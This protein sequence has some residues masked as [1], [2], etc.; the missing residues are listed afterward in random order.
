[1]LDNLFRGLFDTEMTT[2]IPV[3]DFLLCVASA[4]IAGLLLAAC[5]MYRTRYTRSFVATLALLPAIVCV[6]I[7]M[8]NGNVGAGVAVAG[9]FS[10]VRFRS[11]PGTAKEIG[12]IFLAMGTGLIIGMGY[13]AY[14][15]LFAIVLGAAT[16]LYNHIDFGAGKKA[17]RYR[18][19][20]ITIPEDLDYTGVFDELL[21]EYTSACELTQVK[22]TNMGSLFRLTYNITLRSASMEKELID[23]LRC[24][25]GNLEITVS[26]QETITA[27]L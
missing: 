26:K 3:T 23:K 20:H 2:V 24:R 9:A 17:A 6:V 16:M 15:F 13:I 21:R 12:A 18:T 5:Y 11:V 14:A 22:T 7:M 4:L 19:L 27:E 25:N 8:V 1:M 10:L